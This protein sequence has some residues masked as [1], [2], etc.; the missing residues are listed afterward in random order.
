[1]PEAREKRL[2]DMRL[3]T[4]AGRYLADC[5]DA[6]TFRAGFLR[7]E[8]ASARITKLDVK[9]ALSQP[10]VIAILTGA[11]L[12]ADGVRAMDHVPMPRDDGGAPG[13]FE[14]PILALQRIRHVGEPIAL[15]VAETAA[16]VQD[17]IEAIEIET[18]EDEGLDGVAFCRRFG[19]I[20]AARD[21]IEGAKFSA[22][23]E[24][25]MPRVT[26]FALE[27]RGIIARGT[28]DGQLHIRASTQ[29]PFALRNQIAEHFGWERSDI[30]VEAA[31]VGGSFGLKGYM[32]A[33]DASLAWAARRLKLALAWVPSRSETMVADAQGRSAKARVSVALDAELR[34]VA[35]Q[36]C[37]DV[38][39]GAY[40]GRRA[41]G[42]INNINGLTGVY[43]VPLVAAQVTGHLS[44]RA[45]LAP[46]RGNGRPEATMA[47]EAV[48]DSVALRH[49]LDPVEVRR[50]NMISPEDLPLTT[51]LGAPLDCGDFPRVMATALARN[52]GAEERRKSAEA[53]GM[54]YGVGLANCIE[55]A[56][57]PMRAPK[58]DFARITITSSGRILLAPG[59]MSVGQG[60]ETALT[61]MV[62]QRLQ[63]NPELIDYRHG[64]TQAISFGKGSG[65]SGGLTLAGSALW[66]VLDTLLHD[67]QQQAATRLGCSPADISFRDAGF[68]RTGTNDAVSLRE[69]ALAAPGGQWSVEQSFT[70]AGATFPNGTHICEVEIDPETGATRVVRYVAVEDV[71]RVLNPTLVEGQLQ[72]GIAQGLSLGLGERMVYDHSDQVLT[73]TLMDYAVARASDLPVYRLETVEVPTKLNPL[74]V[75]G[76]GEAGTV[77]ATAALA[78]AVRDALHRAGVED[79]DLPATSCSVW[80]ALSQ[81]KAAPLA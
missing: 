81:V 66:Q 61:A 57:G 2:E 11:D 68:F 28:E 74:G 39:V 80:Q 71:G 63:V 24:I 22:E 49:G 15:V 14:Q 29:N 45:P 1:M 42:V 26:A 27:P 67:G 31:D 17:A 19:N 41:M 40:P 37:F 48:L 16:Q 78:S 62:A 23:I 21:A 60:H 5:L 59:V 51:G 12:A 35:L 6:G 7:S 36:G 77:G 18:L 53:R 76:V 75:K 46:F 54:L 25:E 58:P 34:I 55:S 38:D 72:G 8:V 79:F 47:I 9:S 32:A 33:E 73:G 56:G 3:L 4:G 44:S 69:L 50:R 30:H 20:Q 13:L 70:P 52:A 43:H 65:G 64:D 10:G